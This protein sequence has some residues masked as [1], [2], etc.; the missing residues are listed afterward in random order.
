MSYTQKEYYEK[1]EIANYKSQKLYVINGDLVIAPI[2][3]YICRK[4]TNISDG[5]INPDYE[6]IL[7][8]SHKRFLDRARKNRQFEYQTR[9]DYLT[10]RKLRKQAIGLWTERDEAEYKKTISSLSTSIGEKYPYLS[11]SDFKANR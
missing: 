2:G 11:F 9:C 1:L 8:E 7:V 4:N 3:Y 10:M 6:K 5:T